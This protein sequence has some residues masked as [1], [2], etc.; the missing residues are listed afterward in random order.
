MLKRW[1][2]LTISPFMVWVTLL[3]KKTYL[4]VSYR[5]ITLHVWSKSHS[6]WSLVLDIYKLF[7]KCFLV[8]RSTD[9]KVWL[10]LRFE[11]PKHAHNTNQSLA[12]PWHSHWREQSERRWGGGVGMWCQ[13]R[14]VSI[15]AAMGQ[16]VAG[17]GQYVAGRG[18]WQCK[19]GEVS[20]A[21]RPPS[22]WLTAVV[23]S[24]QPAGTEGP[25]LC[26]R[27]LWIGVLQEFGPGR[28]WEVQ[29]S[30]S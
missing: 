13:S 12:S 18:Q 9:I 16:Y 28:G 3:S 7:K 4:D 15:W 20:S 26:D 29:I 23:M 24:V 1:R 5:W 22:R 2:N 21:D 30:S 14:G 25:G 27:S 10:V 6:A 8:P 19:A 17:R 11:V